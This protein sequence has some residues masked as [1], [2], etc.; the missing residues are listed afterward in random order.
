MPNWLLKSFL[1]VLFLFHFIF[2]SYAEAQNNSEIRGLYIDDLNLISEENSL[3]SI[4]SFIKSSNLNSI[5]LTLKDENGYLKYNTFLEDP[6][7]YNAV[8]TLIDLDS[9]IKKLK[10]N[11]IYFIVRLV[12][13]K[14]RNFDTRYVIKNLDGKIWKDKNGFV[15]ID[16]S[17]KSYWEYNLKIIQELFNRGV[18]EVNLD[19]IRFP[20][21]GDLKSIK[22]YFYNSSTDKS[23]VIRDFLKYLRKNLPNKKLSV[24]IFGI[25][26]FL[27]DKNHS[28]GQY[29]EDFLKY[30]DFVSPM[31]YPSLYSD[32]F[33]GIENPDNY[34]YEIVKKTLTKAIERK[35]KLEKECQCKVGEIRP[36]IQNF[37][38]KRS[39]WNLNKLKLSIKAIYDLN[40]N[41]GFMIWDRKKLYLTDF[42]VF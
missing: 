4:I 2:I 1:I 28:T 39:K 42:N 11:K 22:Y 29:L 12:I 7:K 32:N 14:N 24:D 40:L 6:Y 13:F 21:E 27:Y 3:N 20:T 25:V 36:W 19:Y 33:G 34:P 5:I 9:V 41:S 23:L 37:D 10:E 38:G 31:I 30:I 8:K 17:A 18:D 16:P 35:N 26:V 15:W